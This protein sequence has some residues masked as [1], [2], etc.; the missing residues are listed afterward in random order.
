MPAAA[1]TNCRHVPHRARDG[2]SPANRASAAIIGQSHM[3]KA[4]VM[5]AAYTDHIAGHVVEKGLYF[6]LLGLETQQPSALAIQHY[7]G[8]LLHV[9]RLND[10]LQSAIL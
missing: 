10:L 6:R 4:S 2:F 3:N 1:P 7:L 9:A 8:Q 5:H